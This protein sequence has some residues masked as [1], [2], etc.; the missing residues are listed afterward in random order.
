MVVP[1]IAEVGSFPKAADLCNFLSFCFLFLFLFFVCCFV[2]FLFVGGG[3]QGGC[4]CFQGRYS[5]SNIY[6]FAKQCFVC[7]QRRFPIFVL[8]GFF[9]S[10]ACFGLVFLD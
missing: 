9:H 5:V 10:I 2:L 6:C 8:L 3:G 1:A 7:A 4:G